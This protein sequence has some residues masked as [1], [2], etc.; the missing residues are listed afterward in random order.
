MAERSAHS[1]TD[2]TV[3]HQPQNDTDVFR[4]VG[5]SGGR[6]RSLKSDPRCLRGQCYGGG[7]RAKGKCQNINME[8]LF[9]IDIFG[10][11]SPFSIIH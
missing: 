3:A 5:R 1:S 2:F 6:L 8:C 9:Q 11:N 7:D 10:T 4:C